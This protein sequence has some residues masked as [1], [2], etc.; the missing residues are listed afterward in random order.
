MIFRTK[1]LKVSRLLA[2]PIF[3]F[4]LI[5]LLHPDTGYCGKKGQPAEK[6]P[7]LTYQ[8]RE[9]E[10][11]EREP[12]PPYSPEAGSSAEAPAGSHLNIGDVLYSVH[13]TGKIAPVS[14]QTL[15]LNCGQQYLDISY[16]N[17]VPETI[18]PV[19]T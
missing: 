1:G 14:M 4:V 16:D 6:I 18:A 5:A 3:C 12:P 11:R 15:G 13:D 2:I 8:D 10:E 7:L 19:T 17:L 9:E